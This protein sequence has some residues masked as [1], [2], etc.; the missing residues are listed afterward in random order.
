MI[1]NQSLQVHRDLST[2]LTERILNAVGPILQLAEPGSMSALAAQGAAILASLV[3]AT[4][5]SAVLEPE[6][7]AY[8]KAR[9]MARISEAFGQSV[10]ECIQNLSKMEAQQ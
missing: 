3:P 9:M 2:H 8:I 5:G 10:A 6:A 4:M 7:V 1:T